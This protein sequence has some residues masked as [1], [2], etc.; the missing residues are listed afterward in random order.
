MNWSTHISF[1]ASSS[2]DMSKVN[3][4]NP[5]VIVILGGGRR[6]GALETPTEYKQQ[7]LSPNSMERLRY[8]ARLAKQ[9]KLP[10]LVTGGCS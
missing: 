9:T 3:S 8:G 7:D 4:A 10:I 2:S 1:I 5:E 6:K